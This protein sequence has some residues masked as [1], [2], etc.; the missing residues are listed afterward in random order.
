MYESAPY[1]PS[2]PWPLRIAN[3]L[4]GLVGGLVDTGASKHGMVSWLRSIAA[5][6]RR[7]HEQDQAAQDERAVGWKHSIH[8]AGHDWWEATSGTWHLSVVNSG[9]SGRWEWTVESDG[10]GPGPLPSWGGMSA[11]PG[12]EGRIWAQRESVHALTR[13]VTAQIGATT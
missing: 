1:D 6:V 4:D 12:E 8:P 5:D 13:G 9:P 3:R 2:L 11:T 10:K 7:C